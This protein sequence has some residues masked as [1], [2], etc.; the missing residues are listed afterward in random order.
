M[1]T[2]HLH[3]PGDFE[4]LAVSNDGDKQSLLAF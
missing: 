1:E 2:G 3:S 4:M